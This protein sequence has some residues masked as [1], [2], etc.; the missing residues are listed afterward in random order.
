MDAIKDSEFYF[1]LKQKKKYLKLAGLF[2]WM[3]IIVIFLWYKI[4]NDLSFLEIARQVGTLEMS[5]W[6]P[7]AFIIIYA[8][9]PL[10]FFPATLLTILAGVLFGP[11]YG[12]LYTVVGENMSANFAYWV[13][14]FFGGDVKLPEGLVKNLRST[15]QNN[16]FETV[17]IARFI[18]MPFD[19]TNFGSGV[20]RVKWSSYFFATLI[21]IMP[22]LTTF[23]LLGASFDK[24]TEFDPSMIEFSPVTFGISAALFVSSLLLARYFKK[25]RKEAEL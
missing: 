9:R 6:G 2:F 3:V 7:L 19:L 20:L 21:G 8:L 11:I 1:S 15:A 4:S 10:I 23:V 24:L 13:G 5:A 25:R 22:G 12:I 18:Y 17:L 16:S 14:R